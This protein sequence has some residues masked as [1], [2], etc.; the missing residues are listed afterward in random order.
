MSDHDDLDYIIIERKRGGFGA[1]L[2]GAAIGAGLALLYAPRSGQ[3][4]RGEIVASATRLRD[5]AEDVVRQAQ[6]TVTERVDGVRSDVRGRIDAARE[7]FDAGRQAARE[8]RTRTR[9]GPV[10]PPRDAVLDEGLES[11]V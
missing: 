7:A 2:W 5:R 11:D 3:Q 10:V 9:P 4:T 1:F 8:T 6:G